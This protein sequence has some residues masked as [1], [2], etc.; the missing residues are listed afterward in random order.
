MRLV[1][2][3]FRNPLISSKNSSLVLM[4]SKTSWWGNTGLTWQQRHRNKGPCIVPLDTGR[5]L[6]VIRRP[7]CFLNVLCTFSRRL[8]SSGCLYALFVTWSRF[9]VKLFACFLGVCNVCSQ[10][11]YQSIFRS[12]FKQ[13]IQWFSCCCTGHCCSNAGCIF[14][15]IM[16]TRVAARTYAACFLGSTYTL[17]ESRSF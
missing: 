15:P 3:S 5:K 13:C 7:N 17:G 6:N 9:D 12:I 14:H 11:Y 2:R 8:L 16:C 1:E 10:P 4:D